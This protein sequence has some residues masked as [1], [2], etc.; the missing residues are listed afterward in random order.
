MSDSI[1]TR[2]RPEL[3][4]DTVAREALFASDLQFSWLPN[5]HQIAKAI[6][7]T[8]ISLGLRGCQ[9]RVAQEFGD[10]PELAVERMRRA[11][12][13]VAVRLGS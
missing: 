12:A 13:A 1:T 5:A 7:D 8:L 3:T 4:P 2:S 10:H 9:E 6:H 11:S